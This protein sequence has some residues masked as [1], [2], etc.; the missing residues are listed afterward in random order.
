[1]NYLGPLSKNETLSR[2]IKSFTSFMVWYKSG[3]TLIEEKELI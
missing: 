3:T 2:A 1:M